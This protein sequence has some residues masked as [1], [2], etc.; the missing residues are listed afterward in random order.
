MVVQSSKIFE[1]IV[2][3]LLVIGLF[4]SIN[5]YAKIILIVRS[6]SEGKEPKTV[7]QHSVF[8]PHKIHSQTQYRICLWSEP[9]SCYNILQEPTQT[10]RWA[11][12]L[13][14]A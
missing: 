12:L 4:K 1:N 2:N 14:S 5:T 11:D 9:M 3:I 7:E 13:E 6:P 10:N 8:Q